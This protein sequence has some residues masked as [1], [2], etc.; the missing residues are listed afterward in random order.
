MSSYTRSETINK[1]P[2]VAFGHPSLREADHA[3]IARQTEEFIALGGIV[4][5]QPVLTDREI[6]SKARKDMNIH[7]P[8]GKGNTNGAGGPRK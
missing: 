5:K 8:N 7:R 1:G 2:T 4:E 3:D 6:I